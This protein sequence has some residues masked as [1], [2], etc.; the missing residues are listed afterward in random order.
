MNDQP[1]ATSAVPAGGASE[2]STLEA[3]GLIRLATALPELEYVFR[4]WLVQ[5]AAYGSLLRQERRELHRRVGE[6][7]ETLYPER[8]DDL[9][10]VLAMHFEQAGETERALDYLI[11]AGQHA[12]ERN[13][14]QEAFSA[15]QRAA[16]LLPAPSETDG[17]A[18]RRRRIEVE[19]GKARAG[20]SFVPAE[21]LVGDL[22]RILPEA[23]KLGDLRHAASI[24]LSIAMALLFAGHRPADQ[25]VKRSLERVGEIGRQL[26][27][28]SLRAMPL[29]LS[30][31][32]QVMT[33]PIR[34][35][36]AALED[37]VPVLEARHDLIGASFARGA[38]AMGYAELGEFDKAEEAIR[39]AK[40]LAKSGDMIA[41]LD[42]DID[43]SIVRSIR[44]QL[45]EAAPLALACI[46]RAEDMGATACVMPSAWVLGDIYNRQG[47][48]EEARQV[49]LRGNEVAGVVDRRMW[50]PT[51]QAWLG[52]TA[53]ALGEQ[54]AAQGDWDE[55]L[56]T[57]QAAGNRVGEAGIRWKRAEALARARDWSAALDDYAI[58]A[59]ILEDEGARPMLARVLRGWG[60][61]LHGAGRA[62]E[63]TEK[64]RRSRALFEELGI[65]R[66]AEEVRAQL[67]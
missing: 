51:I 14:I 2:L 62:D 64:L 17:E 13:A 43:E 24:H 20:L 61:T 1:A 41:Q 3:K 33:G 57:V 6:A 45:D 22:E 30:G 50:R 49:L 40:E 56:A 19:V 34:E 11:T 42:A 32:M 23:E 67:D 8:H 38:L 5:D 48:F 46:S 66:E 35:G 28:P 52:S 58:S 31:L 59:E 16:A 39:Y 25:K 26:K 54:A 15:F 10:A 21:A 60:E 44:G 18:L 27:D 63:A 4:H 36:V 65:E 9:A 29:A 12:L 53:S 55:A 47:R 37:A 7:L